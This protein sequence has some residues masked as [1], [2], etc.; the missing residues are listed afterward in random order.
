MELDA[1]YF[2]RWYADMSRSQMRDQIFRDALGLPP[3]LDSSS[4]LSWA[5]L[6][7]VIA[8][9]ELS[10]QTLLVD[11]ACGRGGYGLAA[12]R[13]TGARLT[14]VDFSAVAIAAAERNAATFGVADRATFRRGEL[15]ATGL[16]GRSADA[17]MC[18]DAIQFA[19]PPLAAL[20]EC[21]RVLVG[22]GRLAVTCWEVDDPSDERVVPARLRQVNLARDLAE[23]GFTRIEVLGKPDWLAGEMAMWKAALAADAG[24]D[25]AMQSLQR[26]GERVLAM[27]DG[28]RRV[29]ATAVAPG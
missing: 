5:G 13:E 25:P 2:D 20:R 11:L 28:K 22:G 15:T 21:L 3:E 17:I 29:L 19:E 23:A 18:I 9:L 12:A 26:E 27:P 1:D 6:G 8:A 4:L 7:E 14:G 16:A 10:P 24:D